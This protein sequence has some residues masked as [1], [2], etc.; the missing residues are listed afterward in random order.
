MRYIL[1]TVVL[2]A[3]QTS[4]VSFLL[5]SSCNAP[6]KFLLVYYTR[7]HSALHIYAGGYQGGTVSSVMDT[8]KA[9]PDEEI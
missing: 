5:C 2:L 7:G 4:S 9:I 6:V 3:Y 8:V 1:F